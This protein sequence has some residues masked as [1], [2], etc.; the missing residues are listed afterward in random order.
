MSVDIV[1]LIEN[2][3]ITKLNG[4]YQ[5]KLVE[6]VKNSFTEYEQQIFLA[7]F[8]CYLNYDYVTDFVIDL[9]NVWK[10]L[11]F[12]QKV[13]AKRVLEKNFILDKDYKLLLCQTAKQTNGV[14]GGHNK[15]TFMLNINT[16]KKFCLKSE[17]K[18]AD[19]IHDYFI[20]LE[21]ILQEI[22]L[23]E[24]NEL[25]LQLENQKTE[26]QQ[27]EDKKKQEYDIKL[28]KQRILERE[29]ML[30]S[31]FATAGSIFYVIK[32]KSFENGQYIIK[33]GESR[34]GIKGRYNEHKSKHE[35]C[36]L[37]DC[38][39][40]NR[41]HDFESFIKNHDLIRGNR[42]TDLPGHESELELFLVGKNLTYQ[43]LL[44]AIN[45]N[46]SSF[47]DNNTY[48]L[49]LEIEKLKIMLEIKNT[50]NV[51][52]LIQELIQS[53]KQMSSKI[54]NLEKSNKEL[55]EKINSSQTKTTTNFNQ[56]L[57][58][59]GPRLQQINPETMMLN[60]VYESVAEC[61]K[62][63][64]FTLKR[65][66]IDKAVTENTI[67]H[68]FRWLYVNR[69]LD[70][71]IV[72]NILDTKVTNVQNVGYIAQINK[73]NTEIINV[74]IDRKTA[75]LQNGY[76]SPS[77]LDTPVKNFTVTKGFFYKLYDECDENLKTQ[78]VEKYGTP[79]LYKNGISQ[80]NATNQLIKTFI[81]KYD[82]IKQMKISDKTLA[83]TLDKNILYNNFYFKSVESKIKM[84]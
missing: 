21:N 26:M 24:S 59:L 80:Y 68:G 75:A 77:A 83:K 70:P 31:E 30:L 1:N 11:G 38:F 61:I 43:T 58:T 42:V 40:V 4:N 7:S 28:E 48:K 37:L 72:T 3:P 34:K 29:K 32:V 56:P 13:N 51:N 25:K 67:Y 36:L 53:V 47:N 19:E 9:D 50:E 52:P 62:E 73:E 6:K 60:K 54:D 23:E 66:S 64:N 14:K 16:F 2:N 71:T 63:S 65:P 69:N 33:V 5:S 39:L 57:I 55:M 44:N 20:K 79:L 18:K 22:I 35:E 78:F 76:I 10:W 46:I 17:T 12:G 45:N 27:L 82:C 41:S 15:E 49:E 74:Y 84:I 8:Y 81:C